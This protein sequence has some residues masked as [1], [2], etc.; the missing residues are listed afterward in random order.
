M[1]KPTFVERELGDRLLSLR[2]ALLLLKDAIAEV[3]GGKAHF[4]LPIFT[5]LRALL[6]EKSKDNQPLLLEIASV[7]GFDPPIYSMRSIHDDPKAPEVMKSAL[8][9]F[10]G[11]PMG[12][13]QELPAQMPTSLSRLLDKRI[14]TIEESIYTLRD[15]IEVCANKAGGAHWPKRMKENEVRLL[16]FRFGQFQPAHTALLQFAE[17]ILEYGRQLLA[18]I[19]TQYVNLLVVVPEQKIHSEV[20]IF[21]LRYPNRS[22]TLQFTIRNEGILKAR[23]KC[24]NGEVIA[25]QCAPAFSRDS[26]VHIEVAHELDRNLQ[27]ILSIRV[28]G[29]VKCES[30]APIPLLYD[31]RSLHTECVL[32][33]PVSDEGTGGIEFGMSQFVSRSF[34]SDLTA[35]ERLEF[36]FESINTNQE[37]KVVA[38]GNETRGK[39]LQSESSLTF[40]PPGTLT[41][42][43]SFV[44]S[45]TTKS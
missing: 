14:V 21:E 20:A 32:N 8:M 39:R 38:I 35:R 18:E 19:L 34:V 15:L 9:H 24:F 4:I 44:D 40:N 27:S 10:E 16:E 45:Q 43:K 5:Q 30:V 26:L 31:G 28:D 7:F 17:V 23:L 1:Q 12:L 37:V 13:R 2:S 36:Y 11:F 33:E 22:N 25:T 29:E 42:L 41:T 3:R 6:S